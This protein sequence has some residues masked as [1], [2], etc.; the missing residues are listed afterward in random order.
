MCGITGI[1]AFNELGRFHMINLH[2]A[3]ERLSHRGPNAYGNFS[4]GMAGLGH[5]RLSIIDLSAEANQPM[6]DA[7]GRYVIVYNGEIY[8]FQTIKKD[9]IGRGVEFNTQCDTEVLLYAWIEWGHECL[10]LLNGF[11]AFAIYDTQTGEMFLARDRYG[12][13][14]LFFYLD[15]DKFLFGSEIKS[16]LAFGIEKSLNLSAM[17]MYFQ[18]QYIPAPMSIFNNIQ[19]LMPGHYM[20]LK[21][22]QL[23]M[24]RYYKIDYDL[25]MVNPT[26]SSYEEQIQHVKTLLEASVEKRLVA[27]VP[28]GTFLSGGID[29]SVITGIASR[30]KSDLHCFSI[31]FKDQGFFDETDYARMV[32]KHFK[33][34]HTVFYLE[35]EE[36]KEAAMQIGR[37][38]DQPFADSSAIPVYLLSQYTSRHLKVA[39]SGD[40]A[41]ELFSGYNKHAALLRASQ[42]GM[43]DRWI[44]H[45]AWLWNLLPASRNG[46]VSNRIRQV[47]RYARG[48]KLDLPERYWLWASILNMKESMALLSPNTLQSLDR[49][50]YDDTKAMYLS[51]LSN[52]A[53]LNEVLL[54]D[55]RLVL[56][57]DMLYKVDQMSML[58]A[59]EVRVPFLDHEL[60][61]FMFRLPSESKIDNILKKKILQDAYRHFLPEK[62]YRRSKKGFEVPLLSWIQGPMKST[63]RQDLLH[64]DFIKEQ[65]V[66]NPKA[67]QKIQKR[68][69][70]SNP[71]DSAATVWALMVFQWWWKHYYTNV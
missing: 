26:G 24:R 40:G 56:P 11:F 23:S 31:G 15:E 59:L 42:A 58:H 57:N 63:I 53:D 52:A 2:K 17:L 9:L 22:S 1:L 30:Y 19:S 29:S 61:N 49:S 39:L 48:L 5:R 28:L 66:F 65:G 37:H 10:D 27:D 3:T 71:G 67:I 62:L 13:K 18:L 4:E 14:P 12:I 33:V 64:D 54:S 45:L 70:S 25:K 35:D 68:V 36:L 41:D 21:G 8:N 6:R 60:V 34:G 51:G 32:A 20:Q 38:F 47:Q 7:S 46:Y 44:A 16:I 69:F 50:L 43:T 55:M